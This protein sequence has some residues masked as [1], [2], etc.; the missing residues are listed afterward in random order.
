[1]EARF[2]GKDFGERTVNQKIDCQ[3]FYGRLI[4]LHDFEDGAVKIILH[5]FH[6]LFI[7][8]LLDCGK[9][10]CKN[11]AVA[12]VGAEDPVVCIE[13]IRLTNGGRL[14]TD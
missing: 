7:A 5:N 8:E 11:F 2:S 9:T 13:Q 14:L 6:Q 12:S 3:L 10:L 1:M 4:F